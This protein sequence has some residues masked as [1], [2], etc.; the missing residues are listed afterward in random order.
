[1]DNEF[2]V[3]ESDDGF[4]IYNVIL[5]LYILVDFIFSSFVFLQFFVCSEDQE[6]IQVQKI[7]KKVIMFVWRV[8]VNYRYVNVFLQFV[9]D[10][11]VFGYYS[12]VQRFMDLL[13]IKKNIEN[14]LI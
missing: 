7:W 6:V 9:I 4:S 1:M 10:D 3:S 5:Q 14:G 12:I 13:I 2:F 11:I 8:V